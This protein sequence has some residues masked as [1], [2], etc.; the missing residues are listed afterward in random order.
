MNTCNLF[1]ER[2]KF[3][4]Y[5]WCL[6]SVKLKTERNIIDI[7]AI[8]TSELATRL[9]SYVKFNNYLHALNNFL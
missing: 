5:V 3:G 7:V 4:V 8:K 6:S 1:E 9:N 2:V